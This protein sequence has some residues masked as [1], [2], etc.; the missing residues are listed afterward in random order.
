MHLMFYFEIKQYWKNLENITNKSNFIIKVVNPQIVYE[1][2]Q[3]LNF[4]MLF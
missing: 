4:L 2:H 3:Y 1:H